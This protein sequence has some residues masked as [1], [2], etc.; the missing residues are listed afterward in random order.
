MHLGIVLQTR[1][2]STGQ[3]GHS[4]YVVFNH[5]VMPSAYYSVTV[6]QHTSNVLRSVSDDFIMY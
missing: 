1:N 3:Y 5:A 4:V 6:A 2:G